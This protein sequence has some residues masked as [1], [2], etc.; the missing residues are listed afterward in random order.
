MEVL[1]K[2]NVDNLGDKDEI[3]SVKDGYGRN[4]LIPQKM[5]VIATES[6]KKMHAE[7]M[8]QRSHKL[9][10]IKEEAQAVA[11]KL[12]EASIKVG[13]KV[14]E[15]GKIF[16]S[17]TNVQLADALNKAGFEVERRKIKLLGS[18]IKAAGSYEAEVKLHKE[19]TVKVG[20]EVV[21]E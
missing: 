14:G 1:L 11:A 13:A 18:A 10:K 16:G 15:N 4:F 21:G 19:I 8:R 5:A 12:A 6:V 3:V 2:K 9:A 17:V 7:T 20:F